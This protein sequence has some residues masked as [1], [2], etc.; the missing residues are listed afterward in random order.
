MSKGAS[1]CWYCESDALQVC[2]EIPGDDRGASD[3]DL[4]D[5]VNRGAHVQYCHGIK[6]GRLGFCDYCTEDDRILT[7][8]RIIF[9]VDIFL[10][11]IFGSCFYFH[12]SWIGFLVNW[13][14]S[15]T[16]SLNIQGCI[17]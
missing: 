5:G 16:R 7:E 11:F 8:V 6:G 12:S 10:C 4:G 3:E 13:S 1:R 9:T 15:S 17:L 14:L 2:Q